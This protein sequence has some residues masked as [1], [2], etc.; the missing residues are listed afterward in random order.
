[1]L[2]H[3]INERTWGRG[4]TMH[5][6]RTVL[7]LLFIFGLSMVLTP[8][9]DHPKDKIVL[10]RLNRDN[11]LVAE[12]LR[13]V[14]PI[15]LSSMQNV[16]SLRLNY[17][18]YSGS[19]L[20][21]RFSKGLSLQEFRES[22]RRYHYT[23]NL[24][25]SRFL[26]LPSDGIFISE[27][28]PYIFYTYENHPMGE[29]YDLARE[30][31]RER[32]ID[33]IHLFPR[34]L[35]RASVIDPDPDV[36]STVNTQSSDRVVE[37]G[38]TTD[39]RDFS[40]DH[41]PEHT[42]CTGQG[43]KIGLLDSG[44]LDATSEVL[45]GAKI[46]TLYDTY[47]ANDEIRHPE[48]LASIIGGFFG[49][50]PEAEMFYVDVNSEFNFIG[51][52]RLINAGVDVINMSI[53]LESNFIDGAYP[54]NLEGYIDYIYGST[55]IP[56]IAASGNTLGIEGS[57]GYVTFPGLCANVITVGSI[58]WGGQPSDFSSFN[59]KNDVYS[60]PNLV[61]YGESRPVQGIGYVSGTSYATAAVTGAAALILEKNGPL[62]MPE[63]ASILM[64]SANYD[65]IFKNA[66]ME[67]S[68]HIR[69]NEDI[70]DDG[71]TAE[72]F[73][74]GETEV[75]ETRE[76]SGAGLTNRFGA[77]AL[78]ITRAL[79]LDVSNQFK[80][81]LAIASS[82]PVTLTTIQMDAGQRLDVAGAW[83]RSGIC[84]DRTSVFRFNWKY[85]TAPLAN[86]DLWLY[87]PDGSLVASTDFSQ[88]N[89]EVLRYTSLSSGE[90]TLKLKPQSNYRVA[91]SNHFD[92]AYALK[93]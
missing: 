44:L 84:L 26:D 33:K 62:D 45:S 78:D 53:A 9:W 72:L 70:D 38:A 23:R 60:K 25:L 1:M 83:E 39:L 21:P 12:S 52:E 79:E 42:P 27:Y 69:D 18:A 40:W 67:I 49:L 37:I 36:S 56:M 90:F 61:A 54:T 11:V 35:Y 51:I 29:V 86:Y 30:L 28:S 13:H 63:L 87:G 7:F 4:L 77:G 65:K 24:A 89:S 2:Y 41:F 19:P 92:Y 14:P 32:S 17:P 5:N 47:T 6:N 15:G 73:Y 48:T 8:P 10:E 82:D 91:D 64:A 74:T 85:T 46:T 88:G 50:A 75:V 76:I 3:T 59:T 81:S 66:D 93:S 20:G 58:Y 68:V 80:T 55:R 31:Q 71:N 34:D 16:M 43:V 22:S 57:G